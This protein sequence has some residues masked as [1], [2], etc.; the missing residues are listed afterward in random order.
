[1][2][3]NTR[4][5][6]RGRHTVVGSTHLLPAVELVRETTLGSVEEAVRCVMP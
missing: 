4:W 2:L 5:L 6:Q 3:Q 1:L